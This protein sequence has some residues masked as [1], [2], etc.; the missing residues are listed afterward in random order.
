MSTNS[1]LAVAINWE[2]KK[3]ECLF[4][5]NTCI[6]RN[7][8]THLDKPYETTKAMADCTAGNAMRGK[9]PANFFFP[10]AKLSLFKHYVNHVC[11]RNELSSQ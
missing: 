6:H 3:P 9:V 4:L 10:Q 11:S 1:Q 7:H 2:S 5:F 8:H